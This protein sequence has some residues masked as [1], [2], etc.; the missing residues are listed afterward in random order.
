MEFE[1]HKIF[2]DYQGG[3]GLRV[4]KDY[5]EYILIVDIECS[6]AFSSRFASLPK[7]AVLEDSN[8]QDIIHTR[9]E[10]EELSS[11]AQKK[12]RK[13]GSM[14]KEIVDLI[15]NSINQSNNKINDTIVG[16]INDNN[17]STYDTSI[18]EE[19]D[20][21]NVS[22]KIKCLSNSMKL[23]NDLEDRYSR[24]LNILDDDNTKEYKLCVTKNVLNEAV[25]IIMDNLSK[26][27]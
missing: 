6:C 23:C 22:A 21:S 20:L 2:T 24:L 8:Q 9:S 18:S 26:S 25:K 12:A 27:A 17:N 11:P 5:F 7:Y 19:S 1:R 16:V 4:K 3:N 13:V 14:A 15:N 10:E